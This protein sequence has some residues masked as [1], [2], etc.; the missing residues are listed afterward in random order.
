MS[1]N[2]LPTCLPV[3][4]LTHLCKQCNS[5]LN[6]NSTTLEIWQF[7]LAIQCNLCERCLFL[8]ILQFIA[9]FASQFIQLFKTHDQLRTLLCWGA[10]GGA[11]TRW[12]LCWTEPVLPTSQIHQEAFVDLKK[13]TRSAEFYRFSADCRADL[14]FFESPG[15]LSCYV[16][17][18]EWIYT[19]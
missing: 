9:I 4:F 16:R 13:V 7:F 3:C 18:S 15:L 19:Q 11:R 17:V 14:D 12:A 5:A 8:T 1:L 10:C 2:V 6:I